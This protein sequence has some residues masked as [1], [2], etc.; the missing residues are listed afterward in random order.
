MTRIFQQMN[1]NGFDY[2]T[3]R[4][5]LILPEYGREIQNMVQ[6]AMSL[7]TKEMRQ[8][9]AETI[10]RVMANMHPQMKATPDY[11]KKLWDSIATMSNFQLD[12]DY[13]CDVSSAQKISE[14]P[15]AMK[16]PN[17]DIPIRHYGNLITELCEKLKGMEDGE[18][19]EK[20][21]YATASQM[22][23]ALVQWGHGT[24]NGERIAS[25]LS[26]LTDGRVQVDPSTLRFEPIPV[27]NTTTQTKKKRK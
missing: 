9:C 15:A 21:V 25:D 4:E 24:I 11:K 3:Q 20:L 18:E 14:R 26:R 10:V 8:R 6:H 5:K 17:N 1:L 27:N 13:P 2:N 7:K 19:Y 16:Y 12:I 22:H 23:R